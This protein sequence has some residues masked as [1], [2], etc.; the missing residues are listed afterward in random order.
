MNSK[1]PAR[2]SSDTKQRIAK[3]QGLNSRRG[4][5][6][7]PIDT[8]VRGRTGTICQGSIK[9]ELTTQEEWPFERLL[10]HRNVK[11]D[12]EYLVQW[13]PT[14]EKGSSISNLNNALRT[15]EETRAKMWAKGT[16]VTSLGHNSVEIDKEMKAIGTKVVGDAMTNFRIIG[17]SGMDKDKDPASW[18]FKENVSGDF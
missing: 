18:G 3:L 1:A 17:H 2:P 9:T 7:Y 11:G 15:L 4:I 12:D 10:G 14:W 13:S 5:S 8:S 6:H 16:R